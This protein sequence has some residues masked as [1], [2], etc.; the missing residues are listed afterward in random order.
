MLSKAKIF[1]LADLLFTLGFRN[2]R[3]TAGEKYKWIER[4]IKENHVFFYPKAN[5]VL[6]GLHFSHFLKIRTVF[7]AKSPSL[8][9]YSVILNM[10]TF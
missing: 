5:I 2:V 3:Y 7:K 10:I 1:I 8:L 6:S 9:S 4:N